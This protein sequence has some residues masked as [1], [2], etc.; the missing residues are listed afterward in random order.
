[1]TSRSKAGQQQCGQEESLMPQLPEA[2]RKQILFQH[3]VLRAL[4]GRL[5]AAAERTLR[6]EAAVQDLRDAQRTLHDVLEVHLR[7]E[8]DVLAPL[9]CAIW[10]ADRLARMHEEHTS[11]LESLRRQRSRKP[12]QSATASIRLVLGLLARMAAEERELL[13][14]GISQAPSSCSSPGALSSP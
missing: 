8:E 13:G 6:N 12:K 2:I 5:A 1:V 11:A 10:P 7:Q 9:L 4:L 3:E 14:G